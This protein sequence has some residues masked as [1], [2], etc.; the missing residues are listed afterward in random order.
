[1][2]FNGAKKGYTPRGRKR[3]TKKKVSYRPSRKTASATSSKTK[4]LA[5]QMKKMISSGELRESQKATYDI[6]LSQRSVFVNTKE[7]FNN[8]ICVPLTQM[9]PAQQ[10]CGQGPDD[11]FRRSNSVTIRGISV[12]LSLSVSDETRV[13]AFPYEPHESIWRNISQAPRALTVNTGASTKQVGVAGVADTVATIMFPFEKSG[14]T[15]E[16]GPFMT[17]KGCVDVGGKPQ[18]RLD[19]PDG[20][21]LD[22]RISTGSSR[23][24]GGVVKKTFAASGLQRTVNFD[25]SAKEDV[26]QGYTQWRTVTVSEYWKL[27]KKY[28]YGYEGDSQPMWERP[29][30]LLLCIDCPSM[31]KV[32]AALDENTPVVGAYIRGF[33]VDIY[34]K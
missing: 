4:S 6:T 31:E 5:S 13:V 34:Y 14:L 26:G 15:S 1:M 24:L 25:N 11:R 22:C 7:A 19:S 17:R 30:E 28:V 12:R 8:T 29:L 16:H 32:N 20:T 18:Y 27:D 21:P 23:P 3:T 10:A 33:S 9:I 2:A